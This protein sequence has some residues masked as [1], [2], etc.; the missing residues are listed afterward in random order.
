MLYIEINQQPVQPFPAD[1]E[2]AAGAQL[3]ASETE[4]EIA[5]GIFFER[6]ACFDEFEM[7]V[8][9]LAGVGHGIPYGKHTRV[10]E[11]VGLDRKT[12]CRER[13]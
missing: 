2:P 10:E 3:P 12:S 8:A 1:A 5:V 9:L 13:V 6:N 4:D 7:P 11:G